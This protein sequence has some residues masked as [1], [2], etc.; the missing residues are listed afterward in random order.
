MLYL[1]LFVIHLP[2]LLL[3][4][5]FTLFSSRTPRADLLIQTAK[6]GDCLNTSPL[7]EIL[8]PLEIVCSN[9]CAHL[10]SHYENVRNIYTVNHYKSRGLLGKLQ[11]AYTLFGKRYYSV[12][13]LQPNSF[14]LFLSLMAL[15][16]K[17]K[18]L[19]VTYKNNL[20]SR[21]FCAFSNCTPHTKN[22]LTIDSY[23]RMS[24]QSGASRNKRYPSPQRPS[25]E[26][27]EIINNKSFK[28]GISLSAGNKLKELPTRI[29]CT[30]IE[31]IKD[32]IGGKTQLLFFGIS[33]EEGRL[34]G[35]KETGCLKGV[36]HHNLIGKLNLDETAW[37]LSRVELYIS[38]DTAL[39]Y[40]ADCYNTPLINFM[41]P[42]NWN[43]QRPLGDKALIVK[44]PNLEPFS[45][46]FQAPYQSKIPPEELY[47]VSNKEMA[48][49]SDF[50]EKLNTKF[51]LPSSS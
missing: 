27:E 24:E 18:T 8:G 6:L 43:E 19:Y 46:T 49:I 21:L 12:Y 47:E 44:T 33:G 40:L 34:Q 10:F 37:I 11:L 35:L 23:L 1:L 28:V 17:R 32:K 7:I 45:F 42:C 26:I 48:R 14:N 2:I 22:S 15:P 39:S 25:Q 20:M 3:F 4:R 51:Y 13:A 9:D 31:M 36:H 30:F 41:G 38:S 16:G 50:L 29:A 5:I